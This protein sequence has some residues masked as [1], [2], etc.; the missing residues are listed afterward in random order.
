MINIKH[1]REILEK[2]TLGSHG[3]EIHFSPS[4][5]AELLDCLEDA[6]EVARFYANIHSY[7]ENERGYCVELLN[8]DAYEKVQNVWGDWG[9]LRARL[10]LSKHKIEGG[11]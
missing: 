1:D 4:H 5:L 10:F 9:G 3:L 11:V 7:A 8:D 6:L 2:A